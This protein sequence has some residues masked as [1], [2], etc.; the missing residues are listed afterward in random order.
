[1]QEEVRQEKRIGGD[2]QKVDPSNQTGPCK[3]RET[4]TP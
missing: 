4:I 3:P 1:M 2:N